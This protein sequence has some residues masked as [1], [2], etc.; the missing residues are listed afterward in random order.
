MAF[1]QVYNLHNMRRA[2]RWVLSAQDARYK[3]YF[4][5]EYAAYA[6][7][8]DTNL[9][10]VR[11]LIRDGRFVPSHASKVYLPKP[12]GVL[13]PITLLTVNDQIAY[14]ACLNVVAEALSKRTQ[15]RYFST[16]FYHM[17]AG[18]SSAFFYRKW[19]LAY[20]AYANAIRRHHASGLKFI[21]TFDLTAF[22]DSI[23]HQVLRH[24]LKRSG[25]DDDTISFLLTCLKHWTASTW[26]AGAGK[27][28]YH[29]HGIPQGPL[30]SGM[31]SEVVL[32]YLDR[33]GDGGSKY[34]RYLRYVD[35]IRIMA[36]D[37][38]SL[39]RKLVALDVAAKEIGLFPQGTKIA[40]REIS[41]P[42]EEIKSVSRPPESSLA[43]GGTQA[44]VQKRI[45]E[46]TR[47]AHLADTTRLRYVLPALKPTAK[48]NAGLLAA[49]RT[50][51]ELADAI[52]RHFAKYRKL[53]VRVADPLIQDL[54]DEGVYHSVNAE[55]LGLLFGRVDATRAARIADFAYERIF[56]TRYRGKAFAAPQPTYRAALLRWAMLSSRTT[57]ADLA[58]VISRE[59]DWWVLQNALT[60]LDGMRMGTP[61]FEALLNL[62]MRR[63]EP[64]PARVAAS[65]VFKHALAVQ[66]PHGTCSWPARILLRF[67]GLIAYAGRRPSLISEVLGYTTRFD[68]L[69]D[70]QKYF[71]SDHT[72]AERWA[73][74]SKQRFETDI[75]AFVVTLDSFCDLATREIFA[76]YGQSWRST[77]GNYIGSGAPTWFRTG[78]PALIDGFYK[79]HQLRIR[80]FTAHP[81]HTSGTINKR[82]THRQYHR[83]RGALVL[84]FRELV[85]RVVP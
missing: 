29:D 23:D 57:Y 38:R 2:Y 85:T 36:R 14:Q 40:I 45:R 82:I 61:S 47:T 11:R 62:G 1:S 60:S 43:P 24:F 16:V 33:I 30:S 66:A 21:A 52:T 54:L 20:G 49:M 59:R 70:W 77:Y 34:T 42:E 51:P 22:Y 76:R 31:L 55:Y 15:K 39:R 81:R 7:A 83:I 58:N 68:A 8:S 44:D 63:S 73:I 32:Q 4:R 26:S 65:L 41:D 79:L 67:V 17:Y 6:L 50:A 18:A 80:S 64:D 27:P 12:S 10:L 5:D 13:R 84:A 25:V 53:P 72:T 78:F 28:I 3:S 69:Y 48:T 46:L 35:D 37:E 71:G 19:E 74:I 75:D 9:R 56:A